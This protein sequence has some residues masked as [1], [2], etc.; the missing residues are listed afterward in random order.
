MH[1]TDA[2]QEKAFDF[3]ANLDFTGTM[4]LAHAIGQ[5]VPAAC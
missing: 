2:Q 4:H 3:V 1:I 5:K